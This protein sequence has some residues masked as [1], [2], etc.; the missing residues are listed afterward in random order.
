MERDADA[1]DVA[2]I[3]GPRFDLDAK[4][5]LSVE[6]VIS[7]YNGWNLKELRKERLAAEVAAVGE[8][9]EAVTDDDV[10]PVDDDDVPD[11]RLAPGMDVDV[12]PADVE[13]ALEAEDGAF[14]AEDAALDAA[15][16]EEDEALALDEDEDPKPYVTAD[17]GASN[18]FVP[19]DWDDARETL[20]NAEAKW[21]RLI[22]AEKTK[23]SGHARRPETTDGAAP[24]PPTARETRRRV[25]TSFTKSLRARRRLKNPKR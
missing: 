5:M 13:A 18:Q 16:D 12:D 25:E 11:S 17:L 21:Q 1:Y 22:N 9:E 20:H 14:E 8:D 19:E 6:R 10:D 24:S 23:N 7:R 2:S 3:G 4:R 15:L